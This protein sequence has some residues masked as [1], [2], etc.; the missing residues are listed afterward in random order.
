MEIAM[1][2]HPLGAKTAP[3]GTRR[4]DGLSEWIN[5]NLG[6]ESE[7]LGIFLSE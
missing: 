1:A 4:W 2:R 6:S 7:K 3:C 5:L